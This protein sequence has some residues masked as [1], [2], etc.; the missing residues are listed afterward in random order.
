MLRSIIFGRSNLFVIN[1][2]IFNAFCRQKVEFCLLITKKIYNF[3]KNLRL[4]V[5]LCRI[6]YKILLPL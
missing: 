3:K 2:H 1:F 6:V 5:V 4:R